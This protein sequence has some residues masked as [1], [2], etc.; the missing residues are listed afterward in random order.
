M[1][2][3][4]TRPGTGLAVL[5]PLLL[6]ASAAA[7]A[8]PR[9][10]A[11]G[12]Q[13]W[14]SGAEGRCLRVRDCAAAREA[15]AQRRPLPRRCGFAGYEEVVC[16]VQQEQ[17]PAPDVVAP[18][19]FPNRDTDGGSDGGGDSNNIID[20][21]WRR[22]AAERPSVAACKSYRSQRDGLTYHILYG[23]KA[24]QAE[25]PH[26]AALG[27]SVAGTEGL[28]WLCGGTL[29]SD[30]FVLTA[31]HCCAN[32]VMRRPLRVQIGTLE[33]PPTEGS[34]SMYGVKDVVVHPGYKRPY[35]ANDI[36]LLRL[37]RRVQ[38]SDSVFPA[39]L[40]A[41]GGDPPT[42]TATGW[43]AT[44]ASGTRMSPLLL[45]TT[46]SPFPLSH[47]QRTYE[48]KFPNGLDSSVICAGDPQ[49]KADTCVGDSGGPLQVIGERA[50]CSIVGITSVGPK[51]CGGSIPS[52]YTRVSNYLDWIEKHV[53]P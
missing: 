36:A 34:D 46:I 47:C 26:M 30:Q 44:T 13:C 2:M 24:R 12:E 31:A 28:S 18:D 53:W 39:C 9:Y 42:L 20:D 15:L 8:F 21:G 29:I 23:E 33:I 52:V 6:L 22:P 4:S 45:K 19:Y 27:Y 43:G 3:T 50:P 10:L 17:P 49:G 37:D 16:C 14:E 7:A 35:Y 38:F 48:N 41:E 40:Y 11:E 51:P 25:F 32:R 5:C 1:T